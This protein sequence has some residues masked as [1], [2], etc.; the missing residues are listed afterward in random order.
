MGKTAI[1]KKILKDRSFDTFSFGHTFSD[2]PWHYHDK[3][4]KI[5]VPDFD[6][7]THSWIYSKCLPPTLSHLIQNDLTP[8]NRVLKSPRDIGFT[9]G[10]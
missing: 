4:V 8:V 2:Y 6:K 10:K 3:Q 9:N 1:F 5:G 7:Y